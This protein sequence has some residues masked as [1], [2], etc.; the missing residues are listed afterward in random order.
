MLNGQSMLTSQWVNRAASQNLSFGKF[1]IF[2]SPNSP[3][4]FL[5]FSM[6]IWMILLKTALAQ[7]NQ[8]AIF[9]HFI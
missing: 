3:Y 5:Q 7:T 4:S 2:W 1:N 6:D 9:S 8:N